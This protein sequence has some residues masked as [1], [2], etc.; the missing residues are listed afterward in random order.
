MRHFVSCLASQD[1][2]DWLRTKI[3][4]YMGNLIWDKHA[5]YSRPAG[6]FTEFSSCAL[7]LTVTVCGRTL[8]P[9]TLVALVVCKAN[10]VEIGPVQGAQWRR[11][12]S[13]SCAGMLGPLQLAS[14]VRSDPN[15]GWCDVPGLTP[16]DEALKLFPL[17][18]LFKFYNS[19]RFLPYVTHTQI[20]TQRTSMLFHLDF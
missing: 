4:M 13:S 14:G 11:R 8:C 3:A 1:Y 17:F 5:L 7:T 19:Q 10:L 2:I 12:P 9:K 6:S 16:Q 18:R 15:L 20:Y